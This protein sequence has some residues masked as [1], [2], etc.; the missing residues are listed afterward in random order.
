MSDNL[1]FELLPYLERIA[2]ICIGNSTADNVGAGEL[3]TLPE[4]LSLIQYNQKSSEYVKHGIRKVKLLE[5]MVVRLKNQLE[6]LAKKQ[7]LGQVK[8]D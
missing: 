5:D 8:S 3:S 1:E 2:D 6:M 4:A 7:E